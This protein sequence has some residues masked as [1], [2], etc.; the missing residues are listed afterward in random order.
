M[1][2]RTD[3]RLIPMKPGRIGILAVYLAFAAMVS[4]T[5]AIESIGPL[6]PRY[7][8]LE[9]IYIGLFT[10]FFF[11]LHFPDWL[12]HLYFALQ[13]A[14]VLLMLSLRPEFDFVVVLFMLLSYQVSLHFTSRIRWIWISLLVFL[15]GGSL[16][17]YLGFFRGLALSL[18]TM[19][20]EIIIPAFL[21]ANQQTEIAR[22]ESQVL[23]DQLEQAHQ[24]LDSYV[25][26]VEDLTAMQER[27]R[28]AYDLHETVSQLIFSIS[29]DAR[30]AQLLLEKEPNRLPEQLSR[31]QELTSEALSQLRAFIYQLR[32]VNKS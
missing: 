12:K 14:L 6:L 24:Q 17:F 30:S 22:A 31:L 18:T 4:R 16:V 32:P 29:L 3:S 27:L 5:L 28:L 21:I 20:G 25:S 2:E 9:M 8:W 11:V 10:A 19:A 1:T 7:L 15:T 26:Q 13:S 23:L